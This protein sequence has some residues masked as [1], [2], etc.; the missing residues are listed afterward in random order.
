MAH[1]FQPGHSG[2]PGGRQ[3]HPP[4]A[5]EIRDAGHRLASPRAVAR[6]IELLEVDGPLAL[7]AAE[8]LLNRAWGHQ[9]RRPT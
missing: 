4:Q 5:K 3:K 1:S 8:A 6:L 9:A 7:C 2:N